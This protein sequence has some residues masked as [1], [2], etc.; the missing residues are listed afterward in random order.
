MFISGESVASNST[1]LG[2]S[3]NNIKNNIFLIWDIQIKSLNHSYTESKSINRL[4]L[5]GKQGKS[6]EK[7]SG[8]KKTFD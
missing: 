6:V 8:K 2:D 7:V 1:L 5:E 4:L 3:I